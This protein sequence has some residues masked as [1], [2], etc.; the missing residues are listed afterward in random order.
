MTFRPP[1]TP[2]L[3]GRVDMETEGEFRLHQVARAFDSAQP[4]RPGT[5]LLGFESDEGVRRNLGRQGA[6]LGP[7][8]IRRHLGSLASHLTTPLFDAGDIVVEGENLEGAQAEFGDKVYDILLTG[9]RPL[10]LGGGHE[11]AYGTWLGVSRFIEARH[12]SSRIAIINIDAHLDLRDQE[13]PSSGTPF[14]QILKD[15]KSRDLNVSYLCL[16]VAEASN[17]TPLFRT[18]E[19]MGAYYVLD[20]DLQKG[21]PSDLQE[22]LGNFDHVLLSVDLDVL[23]SSVMPAVSAPAA[24]GV[25]LAVVEEI[26]TTIKGSKGLL[27]A[28][29]AELSPP[30][31]SASQG[32]RVAALVAYSLL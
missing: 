31:D 20:R 29:I 17:T 2:P 5:V 32:A 21:P 18:A 24:L 15:A 6:S 3:T 9:S 25:P 26:V 22:R 23:P 27:S 7:Q 28:E 8:Q 16:G 1:T 11:I 19:D 30:H 14:L 4:L 10:G 13:R 12:P